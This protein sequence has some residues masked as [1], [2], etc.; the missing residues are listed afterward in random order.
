M[1]MGMVI[2]GVTLWS[3]L[4]EGLLVPRDGQ[5]YPEVC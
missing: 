2:L 4:P 3:G 5:V 1:R